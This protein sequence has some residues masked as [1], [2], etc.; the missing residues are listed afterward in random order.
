MVLLSAGAHRSYVRVSCQ[1][2]VFPEGNE[3]IK[4]AAPILPGS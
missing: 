1:L 4:F 3:G 2:E